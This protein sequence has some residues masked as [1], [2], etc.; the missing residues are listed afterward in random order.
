[1]LEAIGISKAFGNTMALREV[2]LQ[3]EPGRIF[4]LVGSNGAG[5]STLLRLLAGVYRPDAGSITLGGA[6]LYDQPAQKSKLVFMADTSY[7][8]PQAS[9]LRMAALYAAVYPAFSMERFQ[10]LIE[11]FALP[12]RAAMATFSKGMR[13]QAEMA[14]ALACGARYILLDEVFDGLDPVMRERVR[15]LLY[16]QI[17]GS[18]SAV[19]LSSHSLRELADVCDHIALLHKGSLL[20][21]G[22]AQVLQETACKVQVAF[23]Q[24]FDEQVFVG[25]ELLEFRKQ[26]S[27]AVAILRAGQEAVEQAL[28][29]QA[30]LLLE[31]LPLTL[32]EL[33]LQ[34]L[35]ARG[36]RMDGTQAISEVKEHA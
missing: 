27:V 19:L 7:A 16:A 17:E 9:P 32:E 12:L 30:P 10:V 31:V 26:G 22:D 21:Q 13:R 4:G 11:Q 20:L 34:E 1:M 5:K 25:L 23:A 33:F 18:D 6:P 3:L 15:R 8:L 24:D 28:R 29:P 36:Y 2:S 35:A 14:L